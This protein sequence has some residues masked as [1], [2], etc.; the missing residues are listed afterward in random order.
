[1]TFALAHPAVSGPV[2]VFLWGIPL[3]LVVLAFVPDLPESP[4]VPD[5]E[6]L[7]VAAALTALFLFAPRRL[8]YRLTPDGLEIRHLLGTT[9]LSGVGMRARSTAGRLGI[10]TFGAGLPGY[11]SGA[12]SF[13]S[14][15]VK[16]VTAAAS[17]GSGGILV[18]LPS[19]GAA[20]P[21]PLRWYFLTPA[22]PD[23]MLQELAVRG[24]VVSP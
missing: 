4:S 12:F 21:Q 16:S 14:D 17:A 22:D 19:N 11:L 8:R 6:V 24:V 3:L 9:V 10:R 7:L 5:W 20:S 23:R 18:G 1:M 2:Q 15:E 13:V